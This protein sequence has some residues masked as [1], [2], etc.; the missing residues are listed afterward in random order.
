[1]ISHFEPA[2]YKGFEDQSL[3]NWFGSDW[4]C[5]ISQETLAIEVFGLLSGNWH[6]LVLEPF[7]KLK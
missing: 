1:L 7:G 6:Y 3:I 4:N 2:I 5:R